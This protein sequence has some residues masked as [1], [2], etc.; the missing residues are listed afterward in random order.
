MLIMLNKD[1]KDQM[2]KEPTKVETLDLDQDQEAK[3]PT[4][5]VETV[6]QDQEVD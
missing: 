3:V 1:N 4:K 6:A 2:L 5:E